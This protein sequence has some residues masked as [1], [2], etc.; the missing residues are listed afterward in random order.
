LRSIAGDRER[1]YADC[2]RSFAAGGISSLD[3][4][5]DTAVLVSGAS[6]FVGS[7]LLSTVAFLNDV[8]G[9]N[10][11]ATAVARHPGRV[12]ERAGFLLGRPDINWV[13][14][15]IRQLVAMPDDVEWLVHAAGVPDSRHHATSPIETAAVISEGTLRILRLAEQ[16]TRLRRILH[17]SSG[18]VGRTPSEGPIGPTTAYVEAKRF[19]E[20]LCYAFRSQA[21]LP[22]VIT[23]PYTLLGPFQDLDSPWAANNFF[24][25][26]IQGQPL[27][28]RGDGQATRSYLY[29][30]DMAMIALNQMVQGDSGDVF[31]L[32]GAEAI[33]VSDLAQLVASHARRPLEIRISGSARAAGDD[34]FVP[35][36]ERSTGKL[37][38]EPAFSTT[39]AVA[40]SLAWYTR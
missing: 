31:D 29:G 36:A 6:G 15:D 28:I 1:I 23:R 8:H 9:F 37:G 18:L 11:R 38:V 19:S 16:A 7:W 25:A 40:R 24:H 20:T 21:K 27:K 39:D 30:S 13:A 33:S 2:A 10:I 3:P 12:E 35:S 4:L 22:I 14:A 5:R 26:A 17:L 34:R 32:G